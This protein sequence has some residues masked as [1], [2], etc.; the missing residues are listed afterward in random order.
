MV[1]V[2]PVS[3]SFFKPMGFAIVEGRGFPDDDR[4]EPPRVAVARAIAGVLYGITPADP[5]SWLVAAA[6]LMAVAAIANVIP[7]ARAARVQPTQALR[8]E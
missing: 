8:T 4:P 5:V 1:E 2:T 7:A 3:P 6:L